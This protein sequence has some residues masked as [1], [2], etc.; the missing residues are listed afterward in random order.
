MTFLF[1]RGVE[2]VA[3]LCNKSERKLG[4]VTQEITRPTKNSVNPFLTYE[5]EKTREREREREN[6]RGRGRER[7][8]GEEEREREGKKSTSQPRLGLSLSMVS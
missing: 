7:M 6:E 1:E 4:F 2:I 8:R 3:F 5:R